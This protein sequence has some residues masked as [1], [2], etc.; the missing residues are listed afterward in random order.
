M[1]K[2]YMT[3]MPSVYNSL[4]HDRFKTLDA[5]SFN[6]VVQIFEN[7]F[8]YA[9]KEKVEIKTMDELNTPA[10]RD[11]IVFMEQP[12]ED[13]MKYDLKFRKQVEKETKQTQEDIIK[14]QKEEADKQKRL[15]QQSQNVIPI[16][17]YQIYLDF[18]VPEILAEGETRIP[19]LITVLRNWKELNKDTVKQMGDY[20]KIRKVEN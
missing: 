4:I 11:K 10:N 18:P 16:N 14:K 20:I 17:K 3:F 6:E 9:T 7:R 12:L 5:N 2:S 19:S 13:K 15:N 8:G 1:T